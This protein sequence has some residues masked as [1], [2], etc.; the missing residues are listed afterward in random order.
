M[1]EK[2]SKS[3][4]PAMSDFRCSVDV[5]GLAVDDELVGE[6]WVDIAAGGAGAGAGSRGG[7]AHH[8]HERAAAR[9]NRK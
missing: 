6:A 2:Y 1:G 9:D 4:L 8:P 5:L 3:D 7:G